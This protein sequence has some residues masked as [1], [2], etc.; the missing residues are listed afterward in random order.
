MYKRKHIKYKAVF[1]QNGQTDTIEYNEIGVL[2][3]G[4]V[5]RLN[6]EVEGTTIDISYKDKDIILKN[7]NSLLKLNRDHD[8]WNDYQLPYGSVPL[9]TRVYS[10]EANEDRIKLK[11]ELYDQHSLISTV[12]MMIQMIPVSVENV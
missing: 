12:Y 5:V 8:T 6:F 1:K 3:I 2:F 7:G 10:F 4:D 11:Y 9:K